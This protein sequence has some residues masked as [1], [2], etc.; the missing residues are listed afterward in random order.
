M[1]RSGPSL[2]SRVATGVLGSEAQCSITSGIV[3][4]L[5]ALS[6]EEEEEEEAAAVLARLQAARLLSTIEIDM[7]SYDRIV[8]PIG[9]CILGILC[10]LS[11]HTFCM[12]EVLPLPTHWQLQRGME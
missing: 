6:K 7:T 8:V 2:M 4:L 5:A 3:T 1:P 10:S 9:S 12:S 11:G